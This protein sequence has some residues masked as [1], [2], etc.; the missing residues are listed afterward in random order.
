MGDRYCYILADANSRIGSGH[1]SRCL[2]LAD[3]LKMTDFNVAFICHDSSQSI[4]DWIEKRGYP[5]YS[6]HP[7]SILNDTVRV[8]NSVSPNARNL[9]FI[10]SD[11][12]VYYSQMFQCGLSEQKILIGMTTFFNQDKFYVDLLHNQNPLSLTTDYITKN[13][14][15]KLLG[16]DY[17]IVEDNFREYHRKAL[18][19]QTIGIK[20]IL[21]TFG[22]VDLK[23]LTLKTLSALESLANTYQFDV[24]CIVGRLNLHLSEIQALADSSRHNVMVLVGTDKMPELMYQ[25]DLGVSSGGLTTWELACCKTLTFTIP[26]SERELRTSKMLSDKELIL[27]KGGCDDVSEEMIAETVLEAIDLVS[28]EL[29]DTY[30]SLHGAVNPSGVDDIVNALHQLTGQDDFQS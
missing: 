14:T 15:Q 16:L 8:I 6:A 11:F 21:L 26:T 28:S 3:H 5:V 30:H 27:F 13:N 4:F 25:A 2:I 1:I 10:D 18:Y 19:K 20:T 17:L 9:V 23:Q 7:S 29:M 12:D 24:L 22:G